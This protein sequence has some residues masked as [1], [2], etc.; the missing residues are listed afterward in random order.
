MGRAGQGRAGV[1]LPRAADP[2]TERGRRVQA[3]GRGSRRPGTCRFSINRPTSWF[4]KLK[5]QP[6][7]VG[8]S[9]QFRSATPQLYMDIDRTKVA[10]LG[11]PLN[12][13]NRHAS[14]LSRL[15]LRQQFQRLRPPLASQRP[16]RGRLPQP[17]RRHQFIE[18]PK[19]PG[20]NGPAGRVGQ[21]PRNRRAD[22]RQPLQLVHG[23]VG[24]R[25]PSSPEAAR[26]T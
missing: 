14:D 4:E 26:A 21:R 20:A 3:H 22:F 7:L 19:Q 9:T 6:S 2:G 16:G 15:A 24:Q 13:V 18:G 17:G 5:K 8:V 10:S 25:K 11:I 12:D 23:R 1:R